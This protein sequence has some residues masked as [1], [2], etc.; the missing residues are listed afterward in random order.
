MFKIFIEKLKNS[1]GPWLID[2]L[3]KYFILSNY[4]NLLIFDLIKNKILRILPQN[5]YTD[6]AVFSIIL[7]TPNDA[8]F[9]FFF[10]DDLLLYKILLDQFSYEK[11]NHIIYIGFATIII[12]IFI[13][14]NKYYKNIFYKL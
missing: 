6:K 4:V 13:T 10:D 1:S 12:L 3:L 2:P 5:D 9:D 11:I 8:F 7:V 14:Y